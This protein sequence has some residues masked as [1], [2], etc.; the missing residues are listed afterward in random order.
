[1]SMTS[2]PAVGAPPPT[3]VTPPAPTPSA[4][5]SATLMWA[6]LIV[7]LIADLLDLLDATITNIA[8]PTIVADIGGGSALV[9]WLGASYA[10]AMGTLL[11]V[12]GRLGDKY[13]QRRIFLIGMTGFTLAS[14]ACGLALN[15]VTLIIAR[16]LQ[17][18]FG[19]LM[20]PQGVAI[21][22]KTFPRDMLTKAFAAF[23]P[24][25]G[26]S[27]IAGPVLAGFIIDA[28]LAGLGWRPV[29]LINIVLGGAGLLAA[30]RLLPRVDA[31]PATRVDLR[32]S[33]LLGGAVFSLLYGL[34][35]GSSDGW[36]IPP[37]ACIGLAAVLFAGFCWRQ[38]TATD[39]LIKPT[40][41][42]NRGFTTGLVI[43]LAFFAGL[44]GLIYVIS[45]FLQ[46]GLRYTPAHASLALLPLMIGLVLA[47]AVCMGLISRLGRTLVV[48]GL[49]VTLAGAG[50]MLTVVATAGTRATWWELSGAILVIGMGMGTCIGTIFDIALGD[51]DPDEAGGASGSLSAVQQIAAGVGSASVT[52]V[53]FSTLHAGQAHA[54]TV[55]LIV[56]MA[57]TAMCF[58]ATP[59]LPR[60]AA[61]SQDH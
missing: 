31:D 56:V 45:L 38:T 18:G 48:I 34:I 40:L 19:A 39:P 24:M 14:A 42:A 37:I 50:L 46:T 3:E 26:L 8:A 5:P 23:G 59:L 22:T 28:N 57:I 33:A 15:P 1:M 32:G 2:D 17:G 43:G 53:Y 11:V 36:T 9:K 12:G 52:S 44:T 54:V 58:A 55:S 21:M 41:L 49:F 10:L 29:F 16:I 61:A 47:A 7:V 20:I 51:V 27:S 60:V 30:I 4:G 6:M 25:L 35:Q 13:G